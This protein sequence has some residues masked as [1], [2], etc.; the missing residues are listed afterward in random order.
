MKKIKIFK[1]DGVKLAGVKGIK[2]AREV[3]ARL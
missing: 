1:S 2:E 3:I